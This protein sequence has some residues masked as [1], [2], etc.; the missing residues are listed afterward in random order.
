MLVIRREKGRLAIVITIITFWNSSHHERRGWRV[1]VGDFTTFRLFARSGLE[2]FGI[3]EVLV[4]VVETALQAHQSHLDVSLLLVQTSQIFF[5]FGYHSLQ[6][7]YCVQ[8][9]LSGV[10]PLVSGPN[11]FK[12][13]R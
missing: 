3:L 13:D 12:P 4:V 9:L 1:A 10:P 5:L 7:R 2:V 6:I 8:I 11:F